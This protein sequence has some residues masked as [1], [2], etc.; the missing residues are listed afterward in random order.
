MLFAIPSSLLMSPPNV[1]SKSQ[2]RWTQVQFGHAGAQALRNFEMCGPQRLCDKDSNNA[3]L[4]E[5]P[6]INQIGACSREDAAEAC[7]E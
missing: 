5:P 6:V 3:G 4:P 1:K 2:R 7:R